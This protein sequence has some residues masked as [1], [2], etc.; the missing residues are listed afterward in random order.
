M[1]RAGSE[2]PRSS[3]PYSSTPPPSSRRRPV[4]S[5]LSSLST[6]SIASPNDSFRTQGSSYQPSIISHSNFSLLSGSGPS[7][8][9]YLPSSSASAAGGPHSVANYS[10]AI[11]QAGSIATTANPNGPARFKRGHA[12][13]KVGGVNTPPVRTSNPDELDLMALEEP[14]EVFRMFGVRD[15][16]KLEKR[17]SDAAAAKVADL[18]T[19]V[20]ERYRDLLAAADSIVR[21]RSAAEKLVDRVDEVEDAVLGAGRAIDDTPTKPAPSTRRP[22]RRSLS[23]SRSRTLSSAPTLSL[24]IHLLLSIPSS[25]H[26]SLSSCHLLDAAR[27]E[28]LGRAVYRELAEFEPEKDGGEDEAVGLVDEEGRPRR[29][30]EMFPIV[31]KQFEALNAL[32]PLV[33]R[34]ATEELKEWEAKPIT[35]A[36]TLAALTLLHENSSS[37][38]S[39]LSA[40]LTARSEALSTVLNSPSAAHSDTVSVVVSLEQ[41]LGLVLRTVETV[42]EVFGSEGEEG[43]L[44]SLLKEVQRPSRTPSSTTAIEPRSPSGDSDADDSTST[45]LAPILTSFPNYPTLSKH[46]PQSLLFFAPCLAASAVTSSPS[47][48]QTDLTAWLEKETALVVSGITTWLSSLSTSGAKPLSALRS[49]L[50]SSLKSASPSST[51]AAAAL[52][53]QLSR[54]IESRLKE[55]Y[56]AQLDALVALVRP[57]VEALLLALPGEAAKADRSAASFLFDSPLPFPTAS[58]STSHPGVGQDPFE[59]FLGRVEK[60]VQGRS[61]LVDRGVGELEKA[62][63]GVKSD[64]EGWLGSSSSTI[65]FTSAF[66]EKD[67]QRLR[68]EYL[69]VASHTLSGIADALET[70]LDEVKDGE[71]DEAL[72]VGNFAGAIVRGGGVAR[73]VLLGEIAGEGSVERGLLAS[74]QTRLSSLQ[75]RS[76]GPWRTDAVQKAIKKL[77]E[78]MNEVYAG[79]DRATSWAWE[80]TRPSAANLDPSALPTSPSPSSLSALHSLSASLSLIPLY[81]RADGSVARD[82]VAAFAVEAGKVAGQFAAVLE[83]NSEQEMGERQKR[84]VARQAAWDVRLLRRVVET[85]TNHGSEKSAGEGVSLSWEKIEERFLSL[86]ASVSE[87]SSVLSSH[88]A[89]STLSYLQRTQSILA[90]LLPPISS[91]SLSSSSLNGKPAVSAALS[92]LLPLGPPTTAGSGT[93]AVGTPGLV[94]PGP[95]LG[96][97]PTRG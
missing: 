30:V 35:T 31:E 25:I 97:L 39:A 8:S 76:L 19:M 53:A 71:V 14:D 22:S 29:I 93:N 54:A 38:F 86:S 4:F 7:L 62:A 87:D 61:P 3:V 59:V 88:L 80:A 26:S 58:T 96:L 23:P 6:T 68:E 65:S 89:T 45:S 73:G 67:K 15:V 41:V 36:Q 69:S 20:G 90:P 66:A 95:R 43:L 75:Q 63:Q 64:L 33:V 55:V 52:E 5:P 24:T 2:P 84:E 51:S 10:G 27:L 47:S 13:K 42:A 1:S 48:V 94:K 21:M 34:R 17:A 70:V 40:L 49:A 81:R 85:S 72:F 77:E 18:R 60:R 37:P 11:S 92:R 57:S 44:A 79:Q 56:S 28:T 83:G 74:F 32:G 16:R 46:L 12:R 9:R 50:S 82:T 78:G 91:T